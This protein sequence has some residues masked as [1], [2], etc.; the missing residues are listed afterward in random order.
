MQ[1]EKSRFDFPLLEPWEII[2]AHEEMIS[3]ELKKEVREDGLL[4]GKEASPIARRKDCDDILFE[5]EGMNEQ[6]AVVHLTWSG[7]K[8]AHPGFPSTTLYSNLENW[9]QE[10]MLPDHEDY[11]S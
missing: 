9:R 3:A 5:I 4:F 1:K 10:C 6:F 11:T 7:K 2:S 8:D